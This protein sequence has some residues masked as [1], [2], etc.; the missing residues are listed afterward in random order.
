MSS[1]NAWKA[2][3]LTISRIFKVTLSGSSRYKMN[4]IGDKTPLWTTFRSVEKGCLPI[5]GC[6]AWFII[7][8]SR[9]TVS[10]VNFDIGYS[11]F[12]KASPC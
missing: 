9:A 1:A 5:M 4:K 6:D 2:P 8:K 7:I 10:L 12:I 3:L 11:G